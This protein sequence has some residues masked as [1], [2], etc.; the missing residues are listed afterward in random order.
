M[1]VQVT[2]PGAYEVNGFMAVFMGRVTS[3]FMVTKMVLIGVGIL[4]LMILARTM[5]F[6]QIRVGAFLTVFL[7]CELP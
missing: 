4:I 2:G 7:V 6:Q 5:F 1:S 3:S